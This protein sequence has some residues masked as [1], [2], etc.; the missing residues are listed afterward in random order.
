MEAKYL[1]SCTDHSIRENNREYAKATATIKNAV[2]D[3]KYKIV[4]CISD[5]ISDFLKREGFRIYGKSDKEI[6][7]KKEVLVSW[8]YENEISEIEAYTTELEKKFEIVCFGLE[9]AIRGLEWW[10][11]NHPETSSSADSEVIDR[12]KSLIQ[13]K[14][15]S[16]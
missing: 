5:F 13:L 9:E 14:E 15:E 11:N 1:R 2:S 16:E 7:G 3:G 6:D 10:G 4:M 8:K 12:L